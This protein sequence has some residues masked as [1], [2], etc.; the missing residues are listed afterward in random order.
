ML[1]RRGGPFIGPQE[2]L[3]VGV[4]ET[5]TC[6]SRGPDMSSQSHWNPAVKPDKA[7]RP[8]MSSQGV[9]HVRPKSLESG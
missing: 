2:N 4:S 5:R 8:N 7:E 1:E 6:F 3:V 9:G